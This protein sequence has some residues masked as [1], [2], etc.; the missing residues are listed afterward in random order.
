MKT[1]RYIFK[2]GA[3]FELP[4]LSTAQLCELKEKHGELVFNGFRDQLQSLTLLRANSHTSGDG[5]KPGWHPGLNMEIRTNGQYQAVLKE[6]GMVEVGNE[7]QTV[8]KQKESSVFT[9]D[10]IKEVREKGG[11]ISDREADKLLGKEE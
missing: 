2:D 8:R 10:I 11:E 5:F 1:F 9:E 3:D 4:S 7:K 6:R